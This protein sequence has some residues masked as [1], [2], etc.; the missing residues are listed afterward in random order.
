MREPANIGELLNIS[1]KQTLVSNM[2]FV[3]SCKKQLRED[4]FLGDKERAAITDFIE[5]TEKENQSIIEFLDALNSGKD[6][7]LGIPKKGDNR[8]WH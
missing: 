5:C 7:V 8:K 2:N 6:I 4:V 3:A 1:L